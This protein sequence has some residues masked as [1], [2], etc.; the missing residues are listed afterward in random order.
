[1][2]VYK[3]CKNYINYSED[4]RTISKF[5]IKSAK[6]SPLIA[7]KLTWLLEVEIKSIDKDD[8]SKIFYMDLK[9]KIIVIIF[10]WSKFLI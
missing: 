8:L 3:L 1:M 5:L 4:N 10:F 7:T 9:S 2:L 6:E